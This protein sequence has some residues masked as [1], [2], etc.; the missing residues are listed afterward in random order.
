MPDAAPARN[1][2]PGSARQP[3]VWFN[4]GPFPVTTGRL[5]ST[6]GLL[7]FTLL[8][9]LFW[10]QIDIEAI[11][12]YADRLPGWTIFT[13]ISAAPLLGVPVAMLHVV[14]GVRYGVVGGLLVVTVTTVIHHLAG[15]GLV[16]IAP[17]VFAERLAAWQHRFPKGAHLPITVF[18][19][20]LPGMPYSIQLYLLPAVGVPLSILV[21]V[22]VPLH[23]LR[24][25]VS[26]LGGHLSDHVTPGRVAGLLIY[27]CL[28]TLFCTLA[29]RRLRVTL[30]HHD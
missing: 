16:R 18:C 13:A 7:L 25:V 4:V 2:L 26:V 14:A 29:L 5:A 23:V 1:R 20:L 19:C 30:Q 3:R 6:L 28:L 24:A 17:H 21:L 8:L 10:R 11:H 12:A 22:S 9:A 15:W 27:Y